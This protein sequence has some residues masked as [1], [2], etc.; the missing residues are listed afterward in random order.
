M[1]LSNISSFMRISILVLSSLIPAAGLLG[2]NV[3]RGSA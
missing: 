3:E 1:A 2:Q